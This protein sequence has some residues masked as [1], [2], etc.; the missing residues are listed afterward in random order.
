MESD[1]AARP[2]TPIPDNEASSANIAELA[3]DWVSTKFS[4][5]GSLAR[6]ALAEARLAAMSVA[7]MSFLALLAALFA[8]T[9][10]ALAI[11]GVVSAL[12]AAGLALWA[13]LLGVAL[14]HVILAL[15]A[16]NVAMRLGRHVEFRATRRQLADSQDAQS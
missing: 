13:I 10:W 7:L 12:L 3:S 6:L 16:W 9:A 8:F 1:V 4:R 14:L 15:S 5:A 2:A 11:A